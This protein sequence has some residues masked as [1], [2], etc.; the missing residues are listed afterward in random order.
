MQENFRLYL[1]GRYMYNWGDRTDTLLCEPLW[2]ICPEPSPE[3]FH[4][5]DFTFLQGILILKIC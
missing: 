4:S 1:C 5:G 2:S 3:S